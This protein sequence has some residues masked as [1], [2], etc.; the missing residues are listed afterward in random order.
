MTFLY[1]AVLCLI[2]FAFKS[3]RSTGIAG[4]FLLFIINSRFM[5]LLLLWSVIFYFFIRKNT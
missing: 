3:T 4:M 1:L 2:C 5:A